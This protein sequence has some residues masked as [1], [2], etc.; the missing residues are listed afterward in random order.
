MTRTMSLP[1]SDI[2]EL[3]NLSKQG[4]RFLDM[5]AGVAL[6][7]KCKFRHGAVVVKGGRII[8]ASPNIQRNDTRYVERQ[9]CSVH[10]EAAA[11]K[12]AGYPRRATV[13][14][15]RVARNTP[16]TRLSKPCARCTQLLNEL[17]CK[18]AW[19]T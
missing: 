3:E 4:Q 17:Q 6:M 13:Y 8:G 15:A 11:L 1:P 10:A 2:M 18:V 12:K 14:V 19:T 16:T 5:A 7:S 9:D